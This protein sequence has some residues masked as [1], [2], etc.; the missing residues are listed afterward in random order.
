MGPNGRRREP[1]GF[2]LNLGAQAV[3]N[4]QPD[5]YT[6]LST[7][8]GPLVTNQYFQCQHRV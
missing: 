8:P 1:A 3:A 5:G 4:A 7:P 6:L 2:V